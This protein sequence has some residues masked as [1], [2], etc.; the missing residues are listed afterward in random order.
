M[1]IEVQGILIGIHFHSK[2][3]GWTSGTRTGAL[4][5]HHLVFIFILP[6]CHLMG[7][8]GI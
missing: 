5:P 8:D 7:R 6:L 3:S 1:A 4:F 2:E